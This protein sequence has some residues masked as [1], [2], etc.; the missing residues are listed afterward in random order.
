MKYLLLI[1][2]LIFGCKKDAPVEPKTITFQLVKGRGDVLLTF[3]GIHTDFA[4]VENLCTEAP[5]H[6][7]QSYWIQTNATNGEVRILLDG[8]VV[9]KGETEAMY[10]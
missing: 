10:K 9:A 4:D 6:K 2:L 8:K 5:Y 1:S 7:G 3:N